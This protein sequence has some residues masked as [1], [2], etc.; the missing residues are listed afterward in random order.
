[1][2]KRRTSGTQR[3]GRAS[4][5]AMGRRVDQRRGGSPID[6]RLLIVGGVLV[7]GAIVLGIVLLF[8]G[9]GETN[10]VG[11]RMPDEGANHVPQTQV[12]TYRSVP[13]TSGPHWSLGDGIAPLFWKVYTS[14]VP[15]PAA[16][17]N[18]E[19]GGIVIWYQ[20]TATPE[21]IQKLTQFVQQQLG[22]S[23]FKIILSPWDGKDF[24]H[25]IAVTAWDW[26]L[27]LDSADI[28]QIRAFQNAHPASDAPEPFGGP[29]QGA[30]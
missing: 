20:S 17:H 10:S 29:A 15:E 5:A 25:P 19:H 1:M 26:L 21:D 11:T 18:L 3:R 13:A 7:L 23:Q 14:P 24:G 22:T 30:G 9:G 4:E 27:Y 28:D 6:I 16:V 2:T 8:G 12:P